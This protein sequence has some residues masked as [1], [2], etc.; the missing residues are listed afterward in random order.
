MNR[1]LLIPV[2]LAALVVIGVAVGPADQAV[3][4]QEDAKPEYLSQR[5]CKKCHFKQAKSWKKTVHAKAME[6][7]KPGVHAEAK[8]AANLDP[9]KD[10]TTDPKCLK[11]HVTGYGEPG[12]YPEYKA[13]W[14]DAEK[15]LAKNNAGVGCESCHGPGSEYSPYKKDNEAYKT[16]DV[17][18]LGLWT[19][20]KAENCT[21]CHNKES[22]TYRE[23]KFEDRVK[24][25]EAIH[26]HIPLK[27]EH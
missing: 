17:Q 16:A 22:P 12:G 7:L 4:A 25:V 21:S 8:K 2:A 1:R 10:Y 23:F 14:S 19:P 18:K 24:D 13:E 20:M 9:E 15:K 11:C 3:Q 26:E 5:G 6:S 27:H